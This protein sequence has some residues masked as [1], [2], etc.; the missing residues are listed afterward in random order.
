[1]P[2]FV[3]IAYAALAWIIVVM[4]LFL[5]LFHEVI[6]GSEGTMALLFM[7]QAAVPVAVFWFLTHRAAAF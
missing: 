6:E 4:A 1:M 5:M 3:A 2:I 7:F